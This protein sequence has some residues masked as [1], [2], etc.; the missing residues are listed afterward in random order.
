METHAADDVVIV[1]EGAMA[2]INVMGFCDIQRRLVAP[3]ADHVAMV[4]LINPFAGISRR[5]W[6]LNQFCERSAMIVVMTALA[7]WVTASLVTAL[8]F[9]GLVSTLTLYNEIERRIPRSYDCLTV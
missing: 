3:A 5:V 8:S 4:A 9:S 6:K 7:C 2:G 1:D